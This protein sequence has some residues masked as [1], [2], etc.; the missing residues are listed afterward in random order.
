MG[1]DRLLPVNPLGKLDEMCFLRM[2]CSGS[3]KRRIVFGVRQDSDFVGYWSQLFKW[4]GDLILKR[5]PGLWTE[6]NQVTKGS[7]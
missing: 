6:V 1:G 3:S 7:C 2:L 4:Q 5:T